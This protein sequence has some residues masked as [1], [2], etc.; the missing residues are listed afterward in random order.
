MTRTRKAIISLTTLAALTTALGCYREVT[1]AKGVVA[2]QRYP[3][4]AEPNENN[5][6][7]AL[8]PILDPILGEKKPKKD[9]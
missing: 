4:R 1:S 5:V 7:K 2:E 9:N 3:R 8:N 6:D